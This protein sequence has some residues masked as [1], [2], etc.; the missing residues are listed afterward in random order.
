[1]T[2]AIRR[3]GLISMLSLCACAPVPERQVTTRSNVFPSTEV[4]ADL[5]LPAMRSFQGRRVETL[6]RSNRDISRD[7]MDLTFQLESGRPIS[8]LTRFEGPI[9]VR[10]TG[11]ITPT[12]MADISALLRRLRNEAGINIHLNDRDSSAQITVEAVPRRVLNAAVPRA[13]C[14]V[15]PRVSSWSEFMRARRSPTVDWAM[16]ERRTNATVFVPSDVAPQEIRDCLHEELAQA[17]GPLNDLY[18]L[19]DSVFND[20]NIHAV[21]TS[22]D[23]LILKAYYDPALRNGMSR[24][25][26]SAQLG[27]LL[28]RLNPGGEAHQPRRQSD[29]TRGW[30]NNIETALTAG[31]S[32]DR[33]RRAAMDAVRTARSAG[34]TGPR[35][36]FALYAL[37]RLNVGYNPA[38][39]ENMLRDS[40]SSYVQSRSTRLHAAHVAVQLAGFELSAGRYDAVLSLVNPSIP[41]ARNHENA[42]LLATLLM[43]KAEALDGQQKPDQAVNV[44][45]EALGW[46]RYGFGTP[47]M[48]EAQLRE[49]ASL[50]PTR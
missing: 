7:F 4:G 23:M 38:V 50:N 26:V 48:V 49:I 47:S 29:T 36:G 17:L 9:S 31:S 33:R 20:D 21:L 44:R 13:A 24:V 15:V 12:M 11:D 2:P 45:R 42:A 35:L 40:Y 5:A 19:P 32:P 18:R 28:A 10:A 27:P 6:P 43:F 30:I 3:F 41:V 1:M 25:E 22:F 39:A 34:W 37:G 16:L 46:A 8:Y 14:F